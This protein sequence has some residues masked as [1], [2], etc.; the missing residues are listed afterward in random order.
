[1]IVPEV[2][3]K[4]NHLAIVAFAL[5][6]VSAGAEELKTAPVGQGQFPFSNRAQDLTFRDQLPFFPH[7]TREEQGA[8]LA[9]TATATST[10]TSPN[11]TLH[12]G[13]VLPTL[14]MKVLYWGSSFSAD[15][16][17]QTEMLP[18]FSG[19]ANSAY[20]RNTREYVA[21]RQTPASNI[22]FT[23]AITDPTSVPIGTGEGTNP[24]SGPLAEICAKFSPVDSYTHYVVVSDTHRSSGT[25]YCAWHAVGSCSGTAITFSWHFNDD[26][27]TGCSI[28]DTVTGHSP[29]ASALANKVGHELSETV[30]DPNF[31]AIGS[32]WFLGYPAWI[33]ANSQENGDK[34]AWTFGAPFVTLSN[35]SIWKLQMEWSNAAY[36]AG[37]GLPNSLGQKGCI[38]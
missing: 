25:P 11:L 16:S 32:F 37:T 23:G 6:V 20:S 2:K 12:S 7:R 19:Y 13:S 36:N 38:Q 21:S 26:G 5:C 1:M 30:T 24:A 34:C 31:K 29:R 14:S 3:M 10:S 28:N 9:R 4:T 18:F 35:G 8:W 15:T 27:D 33:D 22:A 17:L